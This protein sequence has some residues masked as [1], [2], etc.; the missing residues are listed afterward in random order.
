MPAYIMFAIVGMVEVSPNV[1]RIDYMRYVD[2]A[3]VTIPC[4]VVKLNT[5]SDS[6]VDGIR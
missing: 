4:D 1:C 3:S 6:K 2:A 5:I